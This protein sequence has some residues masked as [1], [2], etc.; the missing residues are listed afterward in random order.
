MKSVPV[1]TAKLYQF[2]MPLTAR[3]GD[4][5]IPDVLAPPSLIAHC[6]A[7]PSSIEECLS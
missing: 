3:Y 5:Y 7:S 1:S 6:G 4:S 2:G